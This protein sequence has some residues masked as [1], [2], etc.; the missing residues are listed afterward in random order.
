MKKNILL[1]EDDSLLAQ[2]IR[3]LLICEGYEV[4]LVACGNE[5]VDASYDNVFDLYIFDINVPDINGLELLQSL[6]EADDKTPAIFISALVDLNSISKAFEI[7]ADDYIKKPF[8]P[9]ELLIRVNAKLAQ[10]NS[11]II[12]KNLEYD[13]KSNTLK[14]DGRV[15]ALGEVQEQLFILFINNINKTLD[16]DILMDCLEKPSPVALRVALTKLKQ[17]TGLDIKNLRGIGYI[18]EQG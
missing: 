14:K 5:A 13:P 2:T 1:L 4:T 8:F 15:I 16:K 10:K 12:Y 3:E 11:N 17:T 6:R 9:E 7:G 18:L